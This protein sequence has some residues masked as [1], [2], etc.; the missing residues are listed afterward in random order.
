MA[1]LLSELLIFRTARWNPWM[2]S[3]LTVSSATLGWMAVQWEFY[4]R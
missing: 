2:V 4:V 1:H 3:I